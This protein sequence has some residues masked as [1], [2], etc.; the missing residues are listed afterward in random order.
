MAALADPPHLVKGF[1][2]EPDYPALHRDHLGR[3]PHPC[4]CRRGGEMADIDL[5]ADRDPARLKIRPDGVAGG[6]LHFQDH[7]RRRIDHRHARKKM[8]DRP[9]GRHHQYALGR[10][11]NLDDFACIHGICP[12]ARWPHAR[13]PGERRDPYAVSSTFAQSAC[14]QPCGSLGTPGVMGPGA[15]AGTTGATSSRPR[16]APQRSCHPSSCAPAGPR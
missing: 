1:D 5:G 2:L 6:H 4:T 10:H 9:L 8:P 7:H 12:G 3:G 13:R 16:R 11:A 14:G 15:E